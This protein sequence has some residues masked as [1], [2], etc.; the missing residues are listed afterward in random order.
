[1]FYIIITITHLHF[2]NTP[3]WRGA[4]LKHKDNFTFTFIFIIIII[5]IFCIQIT[6][7]L[8]FTGVYVHARLFSSGIGQQI[9]PNF[10]SCG[11]LDTRKYYG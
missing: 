4:R 6:S 1:M 10:C 7:K 9:M 5:I 8:L 3:S 11:S 2:L